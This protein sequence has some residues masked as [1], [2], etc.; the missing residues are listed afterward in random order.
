MRHGGCLF[1]LFASAGA[2][3]GS[4]T[5]MGFYV[6]DIEAAVADLRAAGWCSSSTTA[7]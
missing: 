6:D 3:D 4:F 1:C 2:S 7:P 5:Q